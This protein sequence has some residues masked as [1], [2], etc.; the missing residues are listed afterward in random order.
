MAFL[1]TYAQLEDDKA[2]KS[3][4]GEMRFQGVS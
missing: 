3:E 4:S 2:Y 1:A